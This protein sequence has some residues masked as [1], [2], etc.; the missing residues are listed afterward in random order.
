MRWRMCV[1]IPRPEWAKWCQGW[2]WTTS[3]RY[4]GIPRIPLGF[5]RFYRI[6]LPTRG[7]FRFPAPFPGFDPHSMS[8]Q[9]KTGTNKLFRFCIAVPGV[10]V[11]PT[12]L[13]L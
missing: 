8:K 3:S 11:E 2:E 12:T 7:N 10:G 4:G 9:Y 5:R 6:R 1:C 13:A